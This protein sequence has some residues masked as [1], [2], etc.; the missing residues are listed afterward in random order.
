MYR[1]DATP[2]ASQLCTL[3]TKNRKWIREFE[4]RK[5]FDDRQGYHHASK[6]YDELWEIVTREVRGVKEVVLALMDS[7]RALCQ[8]NDKADKILA[9]YDWIPLGEINNTAYVLL[10]YTSTLKASN[11]ETYTESSKNS[12]LSFMFGRRSEILN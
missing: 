5:R 4:A 10:G 9:F 8:A 2:S 1:N 12:F 11:V 3:K 6:S 7:Y